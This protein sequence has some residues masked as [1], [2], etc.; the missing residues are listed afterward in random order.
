[1]YPWIHRNYNSSTL[2]KIHLENYK[3]VCLNLMCKV[4][5]HTYVFPLRKENI[6]V[7][8]LSVAQVFVQTCLNLFFFYGYPLLCCER[9]IRLRHTN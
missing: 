7:H 9:E 3:A 1:M 8:P 2:L 4:Y 6:E 5:N